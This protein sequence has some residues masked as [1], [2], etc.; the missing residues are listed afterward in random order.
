[1]VRDIY[2]GARWQ[3]NPAMLEA[4]R[5]ASTEM[6][7]V[8]RKAWVTKIPAL[9]AQDLP[10]LPLYYPRSYWAHNGKVRLWYTFQGIGNGAPIPLNKLCFVGG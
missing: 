4:V 1:M 6:D 10:D 2:F 9:A 5:R 7:P 3:G 8:A